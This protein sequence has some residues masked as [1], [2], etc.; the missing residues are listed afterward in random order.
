MTDAP[1]WQTKTLAEMTDAEWE[2]LCDGCA[3]CCLVLIED[4]DDGTVWET[5]VACRLFDPDKR[6]CTDYG[7]RH[8]RVPDCVRLTHENAGA[9][10]WMP[11][12]CAYRR[13]ARGEGLPDWHPLVTGDPASTARAGMATRKNLA[14]EADIDPDDL[15]D[16]IVI[17]RLSARKK[18]EYTDD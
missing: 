5:D 10:P 16:R 9:L 15:E 12:T 7:N 1:F 2:S 4:E 3:K 6:K 13:L 11:Q 17:E 14:S 18:P 8:A